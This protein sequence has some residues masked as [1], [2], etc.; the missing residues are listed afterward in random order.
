M[1]GE[2]SARLH[3]HFHRGMYLFY[4]QHYAPDRSA[5]LNALVYLGI[6][7]KL[8]SALAQAAVRR[9]LARLRQ[10]RRT[11]LRS[12]GGLPSTSGDG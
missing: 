1:A 12:D 7:A 10:R 2:R 4:R 5:G 11:V 3:W 9:S 8:A 6:V